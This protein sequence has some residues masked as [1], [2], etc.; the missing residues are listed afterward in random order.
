[1]KRVLIYASFVISFLILVFNFCNYLGYVRLLKIYHM[2]PQKLYLKKLPKYENQKIKIIITPN[3]PN[4]IKKLYPLINSML[5]QTVQIHSI[6]IILPNS[7]TYEVEDSIK[8]FVKIRYLKSNY[9]PKMQGIIH[10]LLQEME[11]NTIFIHIDETI[12]YGSDFI[13]NIISNIHNNTKET[14]LYHCTKNKFKC[15]VYKP[16]FFNYKL[17]YKEMTPE[18]FDTYVNNNVQTLFTKNYQ[19]NFSCRKFV[20]S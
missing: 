13:H 16:N 14:I 7:C 9:H 10:S 20:L 5:L 4:K 17:D 2:T 8:S 1:M 11:K 18:N 6:D 19:Y 3:C 12:L 15:I